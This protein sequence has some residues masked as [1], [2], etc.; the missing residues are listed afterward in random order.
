M[1]S[2]FFDAM[3]RLRATFTLFHGRFVDSFAEAEVKHALAAGD[4]DRR[5][6]FL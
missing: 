2:G 4:G 3:L 5:I 6:L 1:A